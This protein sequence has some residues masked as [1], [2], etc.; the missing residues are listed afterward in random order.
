MA[1]LTELQSAQAVKITG[2]DPSTGAE[3][4]FLDVDSSGK[5][6]TKLSDGIDTVGITSNNDLKT[7][8]GLR[9]GGVHGALILTIANT[10][11][12]AKVNISRL[13]N[14][15]I[16]TVTALDDMY[17]GYNNTV[18]VANGTPLFKNQS[19]VFSIDPDSSFQIWL[20]GTTNG[21]TARITE[22]P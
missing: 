16:L 9:N 10:T 1:D 14:R 21:R 5:I 3:S 11:Y 22:S 17:W 8:D 13:V 6:I 20:V 19:I 18:T 12:E 2:A 4:Y 7:S 15:K